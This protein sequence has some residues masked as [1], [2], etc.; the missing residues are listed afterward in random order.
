MLCYK[1][2]M[3]CGSDCE[4]TLCNRFISE[5]VKSDA[6]RLNLHL[7]Q[8]DFSIECDEYIKPRTENKND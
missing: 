7:M 2:K 3:F 6:K 1:D 5:Q 4:N 8:T